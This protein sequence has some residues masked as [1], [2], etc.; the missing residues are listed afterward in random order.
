MRRGLG[1]L[2]VAILSAVTVVA[3]ALLGSALL[4][5]PAEPQTP[6]LVE[7]EAAVALGPQKDSAGQTVSASQQC[8]ELASALYAEGLLSSKKIIEI[9]NSG[10]TYAYAVLIRVMSP[11]E[12]KGVKLSSLETGQTLFVAQKRV[13][14]SPG[15]YLLCV[16]R[17]KY[18]PSSVVELL[19][20]SEVCV[21][22]AVR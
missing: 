19:G 14:L 9:G 11:G 8:S 10:A 1:A 5:P 21:S 6:A 2:E 3:A 18:Y 17:D 16:Y 13:A 15:R 20:A 22:C 12:V 4:R 7:V